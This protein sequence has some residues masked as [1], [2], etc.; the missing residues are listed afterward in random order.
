MPRSLAEDL[1][2][3]ER[4]AR[5]AGQLLLQ[6]WEQRPAVEFKTSEHDLVTEYDRRAEALITQ[7]LVA[8]FPEDGLVGEEG[9][10]RPAGPGGRTW[11]V[12]PL[13]GTVNFAHGFPM[14]AVSIGAHQDGRPVAGVVHAPAVDWTF[15]GAEGRPATRN[16]RP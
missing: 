11:Y 2:I 9:A 13:D 8:V 12:D 4:I 15:T 14:F 16:G 10:R 1:I 3:I 6:G 7:E 5:T